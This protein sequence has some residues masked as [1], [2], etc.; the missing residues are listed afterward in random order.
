MASVTEPDSTPPKATAC[1]PVRGRSSIQRVM[2]VTSVL[3]ALVTWVFRIE[4]TRLSLYKI[5]TQQQP[6]RTQASIDSPRHPAPFSRG[7]LSDHRNHLAG[8]P[9]NFLV[10]WAQS[11]GA[12]RKNITRIQIFDT[13]LPTQVLLTKKSFEAVNEQTR[14]AMKNPSRGYRAGRSRR[15]FLKGAG[16]LGLT[17]AAAQ[18]RTWCV[19]VSRRDQ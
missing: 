3:S 2:A 10:L 7:P 1:P 17:L 8:Y 19:D 4:T 12:K 13:G 5:G 9:S 18:G 15:S 11:E 16:A 6:K 14:G